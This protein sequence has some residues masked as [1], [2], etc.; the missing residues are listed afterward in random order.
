MQQVMALHNLYATHLPSVPE[1]MWYKI[2]QRQVAYDALLQVHNCTVVCTEVVSRLAS[3][4]SYKTF[5]QQSGC[6]GQTM[7]CS[8]S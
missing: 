4:T 1:R 5:L 8:C 7:G 6:R 3:L 2:L